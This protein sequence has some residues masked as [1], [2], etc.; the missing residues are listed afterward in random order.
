MECHFLVE[1]TKIENTSFPFKTV[2]SE[3]DFKTNRMATTKW[4]YH[5][6]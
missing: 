1:S 3:A 2:L 4:I 6:E 5:K